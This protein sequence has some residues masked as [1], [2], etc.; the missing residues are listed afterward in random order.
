MGLFNRKK[1]ELKTYD[2][3]HEYPVVRSSICTGEKVAGFKNKETGK[4]RDVMLIKNDKELE[5]FK[6]MYGITELKTE[7]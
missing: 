2:A 4:F 3:E 5:I 6:N 1:E 7:Y